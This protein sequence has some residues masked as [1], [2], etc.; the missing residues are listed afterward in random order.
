MVF[1]SAPFN[2]YN[3][4]AN[5]KAFK[6]TIRLYTKQLPWNIWRLNGRNAS[7]NRFRIREPDCVKSQF[8][9]K[10]NIKE[11]KEARSF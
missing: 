1:V 8:S 6:H 11:S 4:N 10:L 2:Q 3:T 9:T 5:D 7:K